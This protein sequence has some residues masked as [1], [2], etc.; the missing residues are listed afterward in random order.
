MK[1]KKILVSENKEYFY[2]KGDLH[3]DLGA[4]KEQDIL[5]KEE[6]VTN[7]GKK[8]KVMNA[9]FNDNLKKIKRGPQIII[10]KDIGMILAYTNIDKNSIVVDAGSGC[11]VAA[12]QLARFVKQVYSYEI[13]EDHHNIAKKNVEMFGFKN[14]TLKLK[15]ICEGIQEKNVDLIILDLPTPDRVVEQAHESLKSGGYL[16]VYV[17]QITQVKA[18]VEKAKDSFIIERTIEVLE[19]EWH[20]SNKIYRPK[21][22]MLGH[23]AFLVFARK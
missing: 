12:L 13:R 11:G 9:G 14:I 23:T 20:T 16:V 1:Y 4:I 3:T 7:K 17:P 2:E 6:V 21:N 15:D 5:S 10:H 18:F 19:R 8:L 22:Q